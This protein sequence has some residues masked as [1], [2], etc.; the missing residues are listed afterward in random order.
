MWSRHRKVWNDHGFSLKVR[1]K[2]SCQLSD[3]SLTC[4]RS[5]LTG[6]NNLDG[7]LGNSQWQHYMLYRIFSMFMICCHFEL[8]D[9]L[10][11]IVNTDTPSEVFQGYTTTDGGKMDA[12]NIFRTDRFHYLV[13]TFINYPVWGFTTLPMS[14]MLGKLESFMYMY[15][16]NGTQTQFSIF[17]SIF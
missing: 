7:G 13:D 15:C 3:S 17:V 9:E 11:D 14:M 6:F 12:N 4:D 8:S 2:S 16:S 1:D 10:P 5:S